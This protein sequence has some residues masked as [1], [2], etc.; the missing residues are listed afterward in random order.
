MIFLRKFII[1]L[2]V[3][4]IILCSFGARADAV[5]LSAVSAVLIDAENGRILYSEN[6]TTQMTM[7]S[8]TKIMTALLAAEYG[9]FDEVVTVSNNAVGQEGSSMYLKAGE[10]VTLRELLYGLMLSSGNDAAVAIAEHISGSVQNFAVKMTERAKEI[11]A[12]QSSF[13]NPNGLDEE[14]HFTTALDLAKIMAVAMKNEEF[15]KISATY[16]I[17][18]E[19]AT[20]VNHNKLLNTYEGICGGK[21]GFT[22]KSGRCLV[23]VCERNGFKLIAVTLSSP[24]DWNDHKKMFD[25]GYS[26]YFERVPVSKEVPLCSI[27]AE[28]GEKTEVVPEK[29]IRV[30]L[31]SEE[32]KNMEI[33]NDL[34][35]TVALPIRKGQK[36]G[37][38]T[39]KVNGI[40]LGESNLL[41]NRDILPPEKEDLIFYFTKAVRIWFHAFGNHSESFRL[42]SSQSS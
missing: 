36:I 34:P 41:A 20:Y 11:G 9:K 4:T 35:I 7:A 22:K 19:R 16:S 14:G 17:T 37:K 23:S 30:F 32:E 5:S 13:K 38:V 31:S 15:A 18:T 1:L 10:K 25:Y 6:A 8:T 2:C 28:N 24:D 40:K 33:I 39:L 27:T 3:I 29:S 21:T 12:V 26:T 42:K